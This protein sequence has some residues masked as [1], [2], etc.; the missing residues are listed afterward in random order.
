MKG[1]EPMKKTALCIALLTLFAFV[2][3]GANAVICITA[4]EG[5]D[6]LE[7]TDHPGLGDSSYR[8]LT[9]IWLNGDNRADAAGSFINGVATICADDPNGLSSPF[10]FV[11]RPTGGG[12]C[13]YD[14]YEPDHCQ[15]GDLDCGYI[16]YVINEPCTIDTGIC[17]IP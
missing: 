13:V 9:G 10:C 15:P 7:I 11:V 12:S 4:F 6:Y 16:A 2:S 3:Q 5:V 14:L 8:A 1:T 17:P